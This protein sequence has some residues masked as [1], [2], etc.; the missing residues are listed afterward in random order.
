M[1]SDTGGTNESL[2]DKKKRML[3]DAQHSIAQLLHEIK[4]HWFPH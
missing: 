2:A 3:H 4:H 1:M